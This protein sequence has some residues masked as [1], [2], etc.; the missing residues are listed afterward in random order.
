MKN[1]A[2]TPDLKLD[3]QPA[4]AAKPAKAAKPKREKKEKPSGG[5]QLPFLLEFT[6]TV[7]TL[8]LIFLALAVIVTSVFAGVSLYGIVLRTSVAVIIVGVLLY[9]ISSQISSGFLFA[10]KIEQDEAEKKPSEAPG[11]KPM[12]SILNEEQHKVEAV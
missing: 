5:A 2:E 8:I 9:L 6:Y 3:G 12:H 1:E 10:T 4:E 7:S 11:E